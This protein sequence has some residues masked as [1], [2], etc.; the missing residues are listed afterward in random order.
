MTKFQRVNYLRIAL[1]ICDI[2]I[3]NEISDLVIQL[4]D[5]IASKREGGDLSTTINILCKN[6]KKYNSEESLSKNER[7]IAADALYEYL[8]AGS[9]ESRKQ[10]SDKAKRAYKLLTGKE[11]K[12]MITKI[13]K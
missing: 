3:T 12:N 10:A 6:R 5:M 8:S 4:N 9:K 13:K 7:E 2:R 1:G 11:Y